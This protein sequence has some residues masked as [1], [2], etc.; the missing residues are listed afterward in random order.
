MV[1]PCIRRRRPAPIRRRG[2]K[3][4]SRELRRSEGELRVLGGA[5]ARSNRRRPQAGGCEGRPEAPAQQAT[6]GRAPHLLTH[7]DLGADLVDERH[8][9]VQTGAECAPVP[10]EPPR[11]RRG[12]DPV[13]AGREVE[14]LLAVGVPDPAAARFA[15]RHAH[16]GRPR[17]GD[18]SAERQ[19]H[20]NRPPPPLVRP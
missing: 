2:E 19:A 14:V 3:R 17:Q 20:R 16:G 13:I 5:N 8:D 12:V 10:A 6:E 15:V 9:H 18:R 11:D 1:T 7:V 4:P